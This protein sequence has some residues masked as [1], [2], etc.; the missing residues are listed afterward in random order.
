VTLTIKLHEDPAA[1]DPPENW[2]EL[3]VLLTVPPH[4]ELVGMFT[5]IQLGY[6]SL[7]ETPVK[8][9]LSFGL[10]MVNVRML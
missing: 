2:I 10:R 7:N 1:S 9:V 5:V 4:W 8:V 6:G 3:D